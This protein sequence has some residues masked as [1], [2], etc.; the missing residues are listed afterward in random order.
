MKLRFLDILTVLF[1][2]CDPDDEPPMADSALEGQWVLSY[3]VCYSGFEP[4]QI[5]GSP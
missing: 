3:A 5:L 4:K 2:T 1:L